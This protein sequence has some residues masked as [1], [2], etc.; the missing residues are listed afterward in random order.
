MSTDDKYGIGAGLLA[1]GLAAGVIL[2]G[3]IT[4]DKAAEDALAKAAAATADSGKGPQ[5]EASS[6]A[7]PPLLYRLLPHREGNLPEEIFDGIVCVLALPA[8][9]FF[10]VS[11][12]MSGAAAPEAEQEGKQT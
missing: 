3:Q 4:F 5:A 9:I 8:G 6:V 11:A 7:K 1:L 12:I 2:L 10:F